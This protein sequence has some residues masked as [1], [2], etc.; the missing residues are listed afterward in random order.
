MGAL[1]RFDGGEFFKIAI[2]NLVIVAR[3]PK[4]SIQAAFRQPHYQFDRPKVYQHGDRLASR[5]EVP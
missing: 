2:S 1:R 3:R 4:L 5:A